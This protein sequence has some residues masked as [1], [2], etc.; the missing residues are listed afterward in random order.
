MTKTVNPTALFKRPNVILAFLLAG[1]FIFSYRFFLADAYLPLHD[2]GDTFHVFKTTYSNLLFNASL[3]EWLP[4]GVYG[5]Q[6]HLQNI[7]GLSPFAYPVMVAGKLFGVL[8]TLFLFRAVIFAEIVVF[9]LGFLRLADELL[10]NR[11]LALFVL[12]P[13]LLTTPLINQIYFSFRLFYLLPLLIFFGL[14]FFRTGRAVHIICAAVVFFA[15]LYG[16]LVYFS[17]YYAL[18]CGLLFGLFFYIYR[19]DFRLVI[20]R[21]AVAALAA[22]TAFIGVGTY[23]ILTATEELRFVVTE[24]DPETLKVELDS[25]LDY[26]FGG[27]VKTFEMLLARPLSTHDTTFY[28]P[29]AAFVFAVYAFRRERGRLFLAFAAVFAF[30]LVLTWGR[31]SPL[32]Y[33]VYYIPGVSY[34]RYLGLTLAVPK[35]LLCLIAGFG[36]RRF[37]AVTVEGGDAFRRDRGFLGVA[38]GLLGFMVAVALALAV[39]VV[40]SLELVSLRTA[41]AGL[42]AAGLLAVAA[43]FAIPA[44]RGKAFFYVQAGLILVQGG[45]YLMLI[46]ALFS[47]GYEFDAAVKADVIQARPYAFGETRLPVPVHPRLAVWNAFDPWRYYYQSH[48]ILYGSLGI[49]PCYPVIPRDMVD[50]YSPGVHA[51]GRRLLGPEVDVRD[52]GEHYKKDPDSLF[53]RLAGCDG[54]AKIQLITRF[55]E[56]ALAP[57]AAFPTEAMATGVVIE[58]AD[59][60]GGT[61]RR[62]I[63]SVAGEY[64]NAM[65]LAA[66]GLAVTHFS[67]NRL[68]LSVEGAG[69]KGAWLVYADAYHPGW[70]AAVD[71]RPATVWKANTAFKAVY[72][73]PG[74]KTVGFDITDGRWQAAMWFVGLFA[75]AAIILFSAPGLIVKPGH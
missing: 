37:L 1:F 51:L 63:R 26:G 73:P 72:L 2:T 36:V 5:Y 65:S 59:G 35:L 42:S 29:A 53:F 3:P 33:A 13:V 60:P 30:F 61:E 64:P 17:I 28:V 49:D 31:Y 18:L 6:T 20:D 41:L 24:R 52:F 38:A 22:A 11:Y 54:R 67:A 32:A 4:H 75:A 66:Q 34:I 43:V 23:L 71:G 55:E 40:G 14:K 56:Q 57:A 62:L 7:L 58:R 68:E 69:E 15:S 10:E 48:T 12:A 16:N 46:N 44:I 27:I 50:N 45:I 74:A 21:A 39:F 25:F 47:N 9:S 8:D 70:R 19:K